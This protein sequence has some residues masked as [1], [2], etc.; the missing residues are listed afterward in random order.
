MVKKKDLTDEEKF[1]A[2]LNGS[3]PAAKNAPKQTSTA[4]TSSTANKGSSSKSSS[5]AS[6]VSDADKFQAILNGTN[7]NANTN[8]QAKA[9][10]SVKEK[11]N[12]FWKNVGKNAKAGT[13]RAV[14][15]GSVKDQQRYWTHNDPTAERSSGKVSGMNTEL[16]DYS[17]YNRQHLLDF[18]FDTSRDVGREHN[19]GSYF[20]KEDNDRYMQGVEDYWQK[21]QGLEQEA[22]EATQNA[23]DVID[24]DTRIGELAVL[25]PGALAYTAPSMA[26]DIALT[27]ATMGALGPEMAAAGFSRFA[28]RL[29]SELPATTVRTLRYFDDAFQD[30]LKNG[31]TQEQAVRAASE[32]ALPNAAIEGAGG[33]DALVGRIAGRVGKTAVRE[34]AATATKN[35]GRAA[36]AGKMVRGALAYST[37]EGAEELIQGIVERGAAKRNYDEDVL[38]FDVN[39][40]VNDFAGGAMGGLVLG[41]AMN[42]AGYSVKSINTKAVA[43]E[44]QAEAAQQG[45]E[46]SEPEAE[47]AAERIME[48]IRKAQDAAGNEAEISTTQ[49]VVEE[50]VPLAVEEQQ[51]V[52]PYRQTENGETIIPVAEEN[53]VGG[54]EP[55]QQPAPAPQKLTRV[56]TITEAER[57]EGQAIVQQQ[58][59]LATVQTLYNKAQRE[60]LTQVELAAL[61]QAQENLTS[62]PAAKADFAAYIDALG[63][64]SQLI[65]A[66]K[67]KPVE[68]ETS[69]VEE[70]IATPIASAIEN[71]VENRGFSTSNEQQGI[72]IPPAAENASEPLAS[73]ENGTQGEDFN[74]VTPEGRGREYTSKF[75]TNTVEAMLAQDQVTQEQADSLE[76]MFKELPNSQLESAAQEYVNTHDADTTLR[77]LQGKVDKGLNTLEFGVA[78]ELYHK[79]Q[80][81]GNLTDAVATLQVIQN[82]VHTSAQMTQAVSMLSQIDPAA[83]VLDAVKRREN[84]GYDTENSTKEAV[85]AIA[86]AT[87]KASNGEWDGTLNFTDLETVPEDNLALGIVANPDLLQDTADLIADKGV[88][89]KQKKWLENA[90][91]EIYEGAKDTGISAVEWLT[92]LNMAFQA[93]GIPSKM[94]DNFTDYLR[95]GMLISTKTLL[96][97]AGMGNMSQLGVIEAADPMG[98]AVEK[99]L[100]SAWK[101]GGTNRKGFQGQALA[102]GFKQGANTVFL[103][104]KIGALDFIGNKYVDKDG[105]FDLSRPGGASEAPL[106]QLFRAGRTGLQMGLTLLDKPFSRG[107]ESQVEAQYE[108]GAAAQGQ[109]IEIPH[110]QQ[111]EKQLDDLLDKYNTKELKQALIETLIETNTQKG[112]L[113]TVERMAAKRLAMTAKGD[114]QAQLQDAARGRNITDEQQGIATYEGKE[115]TYQ[116][117]GIVM[118]LATHLR[119]M[120]NALDN[121]DSPTM[122]D[123]GLKTAINGFLRV[124]QPFVQV[125]SNQLGD[126]VELTPLNLAA[127]I[128][129][130]IYYPKAAKKADTKVTETQIHEVAT[131]ISRGM[132]GTVAALLVGIPLAKAGMITGDEPEDEVEKQIWQ[133]FGI[134]PNSV[135]IG[136]SWQSLSNIGPIVAMVHAGASIYQ[137]LKDLPAD[138]KTLRKVAITAAKALVYDPMQ[139]VTQSELWEGIRS[140]GKNFGE[141]GLDAEGMVIDFAENLRSQAVP[142]GSFRRNIA[143]GVDPYIRET[144]SDTEWGY[145]KNK[146]ASGKVS[147]SQDLPAKIN[148]VGKEAV[149]YPNAKNNVARMITALFNPSYTISEDLSNNPGLNVLADVARATGDDSILIGNAP[150][151]LTGENGKYKL[152]GQERSDYARA[153]NSA[154]V[155]AAEMLANDPDFQRMTADEK[156]S[157]IKDIEDIAKYGAEKVVDGKSAGFTA[158]ETSDAA[159]LSKKV[160][161]AALQGINMIDYL[162]YDK[163]MDADYSLKYRTAADIPAKKSGKNKG[164]PNGEVGDTI[165]QGK[166]FGACWT[167]L[168]EFD[169]DLTVDQMYYLWTEQSPGG[170]KKW[171]E[172]RDNNQDNIY[173]HIFSHE[174]YDP[175]KGEWVKHNWTEDEIYAYAKNL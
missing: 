7:P 69:V 118:R 53:D 133:M 6:T 76:S 47:Q 106:W 71:P 135:K 13:H 172:V 10:S 146:I 109:E 145:Q 131:R 70:P 19:E 129:E 175:N 61:I 72:N 89:D 99:G 79:Y 116:N 162:R 22:H 54:A 114:V 105:N 125:G 25:V 104:A 9:K 35:I 170:D 156:K 67:N 36:K 2:I 49:P 1:Q 159:S 115:A 58:G 84:A 51:Q 124:I 132:I 174:M 91:K 80:S 119:S 78:M 139:A 143:Y 101:I 153:Y 111:D 56:D 158:K 134:K 110:T 60:E 29:A 108:A 62:D 20:T 94:T 173:Y 103:A 107:R 157:L 57:I 32:I 21:Q 82:S 8:G 112:K 142:L 17:N 117:N 37:P 68:A 96:S 90:A 122:V 150:Y 63:K 87:Q 128:A 15:A 86:D 140:L 38:V 55:V 95:M 168:Q 64:G 137:E 102:R 73:A 34:A 141:E 26:G 121:T 81:E 16:S 155:A 27:A 149:R 171:V 5:V 46:V 123:R 4:G 59:P 152:F 138:E 83:E 65:N 14:N 39:Q 11:W 154:V 44:L 66:Y 74:I 113:S 163:D 40:M 93:K 147:Q 144:S 75:R 167:I 41:T 151:S 161:N 85:W 136:D 169:G 52:E 50:Q 160:D 88:T 92:Y 120:A 164:Q 148:A 165:N 3:N 30:A 28:I 126:L 12:A 166:K 18:L 77:Y 97:R 43:R 42:L 45:V 33:L 23:L 130:A 31:A 127:G 100:R 98:R 24:P 48:S